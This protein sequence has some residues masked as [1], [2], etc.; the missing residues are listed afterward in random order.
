MW[1]EAGEIIK[2]VAPIFTASAAV[3]ATVIGYKGLTKWQ[4]ELLGKRK[5]ELAEEVLSGFY[6][7]RDIMSAIRSPG[8]FV[9]EGE[10]RKAAENEAPEM[11][12]K[13]DQQFVT[14]ERYNRHIEFFAGLQAKRYRMRA[15]F[16][17]AAEQ[18][19]V[20]INEAIA[21][22]I[23]AARM[24]GMRVAQQWTTLDPKLSIELDHAV[25]EAG[26]END[27]VSAKIN[28]AVKLIESVCRPIL[29]G[30]RK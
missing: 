19:F 23:T 20:L 1:T 8:G 4:T 26:G 14:I 6:Q 24:R 16:G 21:K 29:E 22:V 13:L 3:A 12:I 2:A 17:P 10:S 30:K 5:V 9:G 25:W 11:K 15:L 27:I 7:M 18:A 28:E